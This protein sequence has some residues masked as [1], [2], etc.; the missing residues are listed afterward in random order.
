MGEG[1]AV[2]GLTGE[3]V[4]TYIQEYNFVTM[5]ER[6]GKKKK[7]DLVTVERIDWFHHVSICKGGARGRLG[8]YQTLPPPQVILINSKI[9]KG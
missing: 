5:R 3:V 2:T 7:W 1:R 4:C 8:V 6:G 9:R